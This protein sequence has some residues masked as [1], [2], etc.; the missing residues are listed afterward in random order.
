MLSSVSHKADFVT[1]DLWTA[2][3]LSLWTGYMSFR[4]GGHTRQ[5]QALVPPLQAC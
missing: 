1:M 5:N 4:A 3:H 2:V